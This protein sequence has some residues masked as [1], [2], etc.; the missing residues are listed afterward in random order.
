MIDN[1]KQSMKKY[2]SSD[3][4]KNWQREYR[5]K[6]HS[7]PLKREILLRQKREN[8]RKNI[9]TR[10]LANSKKRALKENLEFS[11]IRE[12]III[13]E[14]CP[15]L[16]IPIF[17]GTKGN[18]LNSPSIDRVNNNLGYVKENI[19]IVSSLANTMKNCASKD[20]LLTFCKN[21]PNYLEINDI[22]QTTEN[23]ESVEL[24]DKEPL[25]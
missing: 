4:F 24:K 11:L 2:R 6:Q 17:P 3:K 14:F 12:D 8:S 9:I 13:P 10:M 20:Q 22:V 7:D 21:L 25:G 16:E 18:Y 5:K 23:K 1:K 19:R 15:L